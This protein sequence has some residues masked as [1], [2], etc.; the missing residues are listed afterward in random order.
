L[1]T[2]GVAVCHADAGGGNPVRGA[3]GLFERDAED[4]CLSGLA[5]EDGPTGALLADSITYRITVR[6]RAGLK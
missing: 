5:L 6:L 4:P 1:S 2:A 3:Q